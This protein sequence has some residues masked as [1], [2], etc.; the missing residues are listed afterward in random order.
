[1]LRKRVVNSYIEST[2]ISVFCLKK[3]CPQGGILPPLSYCLVKDSVLTLLNGCGY[4]SQGFADDLTLLIIGKFISTLCELV[5]ITLTN[6][7]SR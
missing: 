5:F 2:K 7:Q 6:S 4:Y 1:M 3:K